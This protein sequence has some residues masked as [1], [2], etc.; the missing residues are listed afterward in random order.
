MKQTKLFVSDI[1]RRRFLQVGLRGA[2][3]AAATPLILEQ[4]LACSRSTDPQPAAEPVDRALL[5]K[6]IRKALEQGGHFADVYVENRT[7][8]NILMEEGRFK[9]AEFAITRGAG[10]RVILGDKTGYAY[11]DEVTEEKLLRAAEVAAYIAKGGETVRPVNVHESPHPSYVTV[12]L[13][14]DQVADDKR[15]DVM[16]RAHQAALDYDKRIRMASVSYYDE[17]RGRTIATSEG[18]YLEDKLP[19]LFFIVQ[20]LAVG[21][22]ARHMGRERLSR[23]SGFEMFDEVTPEQV[24]RNCARESVAMLEAQ[25]APAGKMD[26]VM[27]NGW[28]GV[29][30]HE[31]VGHPLEADNIARQIGAFTGKLGQKVASP[32]FTMIDDGTIANARGT[33]DFDDEGTPMKRNVLIQDGV[34]VRFMTDVLSAR[35]LEMERT[36]NGRRESFRYFPIPRMTNTYI[37]AGKDRPADIVSSTKSGLYVQSLS[38]GS[39]NPTTGVFNFTCREAYLIENGRKTA[40]VKGAT[41]IGNCLEIIQN[42]DAVGDDLAFGPGICGK[43]QSAEVTCGQPTV[44]IRGINVGGTRARATT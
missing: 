9:T 18:L 36:G 24:A 42:I 31:A 11:T 12:K 27:E 39:V 5:D 37:Q 4:F 32:V 7:A 14:L 35:Q 10:V 44:R 15:L 16:R 25:D 29:L 21:D 2:V 13:P 20:A 34:L 6:V 1:P 40:P 17:V 19:L 23:H 3:A 38:G 28:G 30:V 26:V 41:L 43:G 8:R 33:T 22:K